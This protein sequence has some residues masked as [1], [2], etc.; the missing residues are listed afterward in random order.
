[1][2]CISWHHFLSFIYF[3]VALMFLFCTLCFA[4]VHRVRVCCYSLL[5]CLVFHTS[6]Y[7][8]AFLSTSSGRRTCSRI[9]LKAI[10]LRPLVP[11]CWFECFMWRSWHSLVEKKTSISTESRAHMFVCVRFSF[12]CTSIKVCHIMISLI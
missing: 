8:L 12:L 9:L 5:V 1:M 2:V 3:P 6:I 11:H 10:C 4:E 7:I